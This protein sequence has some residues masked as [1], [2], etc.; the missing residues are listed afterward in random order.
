MPAPPALE[1]ASAMPVDDSRAVEVVGG[2]LATDAIPG[3]NADPEAAHLAG[4]MTEHT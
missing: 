4:H 2:E 1:R 3:E